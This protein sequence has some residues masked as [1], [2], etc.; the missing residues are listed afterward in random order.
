MENG[1]TTA[2]GAEMIDGG[3][4]AMHELIRRL[5]LSFVDEDAIL[6]ITGS[7]DSFRPENHRQF[8][9]TQHSASSIDQSAIASFSNAV[10]LRGADGTELAKN[11]FGCTE[12]IQ[13]GVLEFGTIVTSDTFNFLVC[14]V[15]DESH[16]VFD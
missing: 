4:V 1:T 5:H 10:L 2:K 6:N 7:T 9:F 13:D 15:F 12:V 16:K 8:R 14:L 3:L 11:S